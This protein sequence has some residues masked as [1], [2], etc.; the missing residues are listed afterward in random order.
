MCTHADVAIAGER[1]LLS[2]KPDGHLLRG[3]KGD[4]SVELD[5][6][7]LECT[8]VIGSCRLTDL[9]V[10]KTPTGH[11]VACRPQSHVRIVFN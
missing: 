1:T 6:R 5:L 3:S 2:L 4:M 7:Q 8:L 10:K 11:V 9:S